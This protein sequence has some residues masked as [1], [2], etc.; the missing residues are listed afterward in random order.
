MNLTS[1]TSGGISICHSWIANRDFP[2]PPATYYFE[3]FSELYKG[4]FGAYGF[5]NGD[6]VYINACW[7]DADDPNGIFQCPI[8]HPSSANG[9]KS[10]S[11]CYKVNAKGQKEYYK[12]PNNVTQNYDGNYNTDT[13]NTLL[14]NLQS[15]L[16]QANTAA[17]NLKNILKKSNNNIN[18]PT[19]LKEQ[20]SAH[21][22][23]QTDSDHTISNPTNNNNGT[24]AST[25]NNQ[26]N[27]TNATEPTTNAT[28]STT[29][30]KFD[31]GNISSAFTTAKTAVPPARQ[32]RIST[33][34]TPR[35][36][37]IQRSTKTFTPK[38]KRIQE[39]ATPDRPIQT[40]ERVSTF[41][42]RQH[43]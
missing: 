28:Q 1:S 2:G 4:Y 21:P 19:S 33:E 20:V 6:F 43:H 3:D 29:A 26:S 22:T 34:S 30:K 7:S 42:S 41:H 12:I 40:K 9:A 27:T 14:T 10:L 36:S 31:F 17:S 8:T 38:V 13:I 24:P 18:I 35:Q 37:A 11:E 5:M 15:A 32:V 16:D 25:S 39:T 23:T